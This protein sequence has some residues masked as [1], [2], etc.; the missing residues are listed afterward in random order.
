MVHIFCG[1]YFA[2]FGFVILESFIAKDRF[3]YLKT[4][5][6]VGVDYIAFEDQKLNRKNETFLKNPPKILVKSLV[7]KRSVLPALGNLNPPNIAFLKP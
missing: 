3:D 2:V 4:A 5:H 1:Q 7:L 6:V